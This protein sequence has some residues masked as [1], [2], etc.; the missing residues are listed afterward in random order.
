MSE[1]VLRDQRDLVTGWQIFLNRQGCAGPRATWLAE[2]GIMGPVTR[3]ALLRFQSAQGLPGSA[4]ID[5]LTAAK[6][7]ALGKWDFV[8]AA[9]FNKRRR[10]SIKWIVVHTTESVGGA[11]AVMRWFGNLSAPRYPAPQASAHFAV[12]SDAVVQGVLE[13][14]VSWHANEANELGIGIEHCAFARWRVEEWS[15]PG[16]ARMLD[17]SAKLVSEL[18]DRWQIPK[19]RITGEQ[20][21]AGEPGILGHCDVNAGVGRTGGHVDPGIS[22]PWP[23]YISSV[24]GA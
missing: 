24:N 6:A 4:T 16:A 14:D 20:F 17:R 12:D 11:L 15:A 21:A 9:H 2:D 1:L 22:F 10:T 19:A 18:C 5:E 7:R 3:A 8:Q 13:S 23:R